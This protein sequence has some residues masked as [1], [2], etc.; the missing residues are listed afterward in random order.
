MQKSSRSPANNGNI[1]DRAHQNKVFT[2]LRH[3]VEWRSSMHSEDASNDRVAVYSTRRKTFITDCEDVAIRLRINNHNRSESS[4]KLCCCRNTY[5]CRLRNRNMWKV[6]EK[7]FYDAIFI[8]H[9]HI[10]FRQNYEIQSTLEI[11]K[12]ALQEDHLMTMTQNQFQNCYTLEYLFG[13]KVYSLL[14]NVIFRFLKG[15]QDRFKILKRILTMCSMRSFYSSQTQLLENQN[16]SFSLYT[17]AAATII[18]NFSSRVIFLSIGLPIRQVQD[19]LKLSLDADTRGRVETRPR[20]IVLLTAR[21]L[22]LCSVLVLGRCA[23]RQWRDLS[24]Y[25]ET[26]FYMSRG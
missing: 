21:E 11:L 23:K 8:K 9:A 3:V 18:V 13:K 17:C 22:V 12:R 26:R 4:S 15:F 6:V 24:G 7:L 25:G 14:Y 2:A 16:I 1:F 19:C 20:R 5:H 10:R